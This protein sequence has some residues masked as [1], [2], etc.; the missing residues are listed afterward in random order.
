MN[1]LIQ[2]Q[3]KEMY[4]KFSDKAND[5]INDVIIRL[6]KNVNFKKKKKKKMDLFFIH[7][8]EKLQISYKKEIGQ[9]S[10]KQ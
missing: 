8:L 1:S 4:D 9:T 7:L 2:D 10:T 3:I 6:A 5:F